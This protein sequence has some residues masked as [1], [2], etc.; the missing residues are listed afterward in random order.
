MD[1][2]NKLINSFLNG[3]K[4]V[5][6]EY[7]EMGFDSLIERIS[8][9]D[10]L[11]QE[12]P[13]LKSLYTLNNI[14]SN[15]QEA[16]FVKKYACFIGVI[17]Q[18]ISSNDME[19]IKKLLVHNQNMHKLIENTIVQLDR[20][21]SELKAK[22]LGL[23]FV[24]TFDKNIFTIDEYNTLLFSIDNIHPTVGFPLL[25]KYYDIE[26]KKQETET[27]ISLLKLN[28]EE[29]N[30]DYSSI[31]Q[32]CLIKI[33]IAFIGGGN[34]NGSSPGIPRGGSLNELGIKFCEHIIK[35]TYKEI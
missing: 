25:K 19:K 6:T 34:A 28:S 4:E 16:F 24:K 2:K 20:Y 11:L 13:F 23:L 26:M 15:I 18:V 35:E 21:Q 9:S 22:V 5:L 1:E 29:A 30:L 31:V 3:S 10:S 27:N 33:P 17:N 14:R 8:S 32:S 7:G 12:I